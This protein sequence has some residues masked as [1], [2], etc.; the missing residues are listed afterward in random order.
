MAAK[1]IRLFNNN[2][3]AF[4]RLRRQALTLILSRIAHMSQWRSAVYC[5]F[6]NST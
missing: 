5:R 3:V 6:A 2:P 1:F 4:G